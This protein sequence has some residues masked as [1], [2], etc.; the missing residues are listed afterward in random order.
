M[1]AFPMIGS[2]KICGLVMSLFIEV[3]E[4]DYDST[5]NYLLTSRNVTAVDCPGV[6]PDHK[7]YTVSGMTK[8]SVSEG[9]K[10]PISEGSYIRARVWAECVPRGGVDESV[11]DYWSV[12]SVWLCDAT[13]I[14][15]LK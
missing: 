1:A 3:A 9:S 5:F 4:Q 7:I 13:K 15:I 14:E 12:F 6:D 8:I 11:T 10:M 2:G